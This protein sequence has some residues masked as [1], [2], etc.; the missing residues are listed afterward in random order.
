MCS[1]HIFHAAW[2]KTQI[3]AKRMHMADETDEPHDGLALDEF[4][5]ETNVLLEPRRGSPRRIHLGCTVRALMALMGLAVVSLALGRLG[6]RRFAKAAE[7]QTVQL[8][9]TPPTTQP[10]LTAGPGCP[11]SCGAYTAC[12][13]T[14]KNI[15][16][17]QPEPRTRLFNK[18][19]VVFQEEF[20][21]PEVNGIQCK[22]PNL[23]M[24]DDFCDCPGC[25]DEDRHTCETCGTDLPADSQV[26]VTAD[27]LLTCSEECGATDSIAGACIGG[28]QALPEGVEVFTCPDGCRI[29][30]AAQNDGYCDC[31]GDC[32]DEQD[33][34]CNSCGCPSACNRPADQCRD[35]CGQVFACPNGYRCN[36]PFQWVNDNICDCE[37]CA[38]EQLWTCENCDCPRSCSSFFN[39]CESITDTWTC[40][41]HGCQIPSDAV[42]DYTCNCPDCADELMFTCDTCGDG[43]PTTCGGS[44]DRN[45]CF[46]PFADTRRF[47]C[48]SVSGWDIELNFKNDLVC[49]CPD[50]E[51]EDFVTC[52]T[53]SG[54]PTV[55][56]E[57]VRCFDIF[58]CPDDGC[59]IPLSYQNDGYCDCPGT[60]ADEPDNF[61]CSSCTCADECGRTPLAEGV[62]GVNY[63]FPLANR[64]NPF[65]Q[66]RLS[67]TNDT[68]ARSGH[69]KGHWISR[70]DSEAQRDRTLRR[71]PLRKTQDSQDAEDG[72]SGAFD[73]GDGCTLDNRRFVNDRVCDCPNCADEVLFTCESCLPG[74]PVDL[75]FPQ[76]QTQAAAVGASIGVAA[77]LA[78]GLGLGLGLTG[79]LAALVVSRG[80]IV[81]ESNQD[82]GNNVAVQESLKR[83]LARVAGGVAESAVTLLWACLSALGD[84]I[85]TRVASPLRQLA[86]VV[87]LCFEIEV[88]D[89]ADGVDVCTKLMRVSG[90]GIESVI[91][92]ELAKTDAKVTVRV[93]EWSPDP[94]PMTLS[95]TAQTLETKVP[96]DDGP[97]RIPSL[98][99]P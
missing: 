42:N 76:G 96:V 93:V 12:S 23:Y 57:F 32:A 31:P 94:N 6:Y 66:R 86:S 40:P 71:S 68:N 55:P 16:S 35:F 91:R 77:G 72:R 60:C 58:T 44:Q 83:A 62:L 39:S 29:Q 80:T 11:A 15:R 69:R 5:A 54:C 99:G 36:I 50:C 82:L 10:R 34:T 45:R 89:E 33:F 30:A 51:D 25:E 64:P 59:E 85:I 20:D 92:E 18:D 13:Q 79:P 7:D 2:H 74:T 67:A 47:T 46:Q 14:G 90:P 28:G 78:L 8:Q 49:D 41:N 38:D 4:D 9:Q 84:P 97:I 70:T 61:T 24:N 73:C 53:C 48:E 37:D 3:P 1:H 19:N 87:T 56:G 65:Q 81:L 63:T 27:V 26:L 22:I 17:Q 43:C 95:P 98:T 88:R 21:C 52:E 75:A